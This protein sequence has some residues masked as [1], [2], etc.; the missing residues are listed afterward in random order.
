MFSIVFIYCYKSF[1]EG[2]LNTNI[3]RTKG[4]FKHMYRHYPSLCNKTL[5][6][7]QPISLSLAVFSSEFYDRA[8]G[9]TSC[10]VSD[11]FNLQ[12][13]HKPTSTDTK[14]ER[15]PFWPPQKSPMKFRQNSSFVHSYMQPESTICH[16]SNMML[17][18]VSV[19]HILFCCCQIKSY[20]FLTCWILNISQFTTGKYPADH[21]SETRDTEYKNHK[22]WT[23]I[24][25]NLSIILNLITLIS[26]RWFLNWWKFYSWYLQF[27]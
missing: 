9:I 25:W 4:F 3:F 19:I 16:M 10:A 21:Y 12:V 7:N 27:P 5:P 1:I 17:T 22:F 26:Y 6:Q 2:V 18:K 13:P 11:R 24:V 14:I 23:R 8:N 20:Y 15:N